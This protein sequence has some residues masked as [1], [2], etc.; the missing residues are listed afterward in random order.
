MRPGALRRR[1][2]AMVAYHGIV[3]LAR[4]QGGGPSVQLREEWGPINN[5]L[6]RVQ[7]RHEAA[8]L[9]NRPPSVWTCAWMSMA[10][11]STLSGMRRS[12]ATKG[13]LL[14]VPS[15]LLL[16][17]FTPNDQQARALR[18]P[19]DPTGTEVHAIA[20]CAED[21]AEEQL[22]RAPRCWL[23]LPGSPRGDVA[24]IHT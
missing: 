4:E 17:R 3:V 8:G 14:L 19:N 10:D 7:A 20:R 23:L 5:H 21:H 22:L 12:E 24:I 18:S 13:D 15:Y 1:Q 2:Q 9:M 6:P 16:L 11:Q